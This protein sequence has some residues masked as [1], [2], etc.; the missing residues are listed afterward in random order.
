VVLA[1]G[2]FAAPEPHGPVIGGV[3]IFKQQMI[4]AFAV[5]GITVHFVENWHLYH[6]LGGEVHCGSNALRATPADVRWWETG[7]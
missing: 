4:D 7:R 3:D 2:H 6:A 5:H 1:D